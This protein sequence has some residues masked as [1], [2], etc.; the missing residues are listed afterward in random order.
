MLTT[1]EE[2]KV[3]LFVESILPRVDRC[4]LP[5]G[6]CFVQSHYVPMSNKVT[7]KDGAEDVLTNVIVVCHSFSLEQKVRSRLIGST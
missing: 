1:T 2:R 6:L 4:K 3:N 5:A 7:E